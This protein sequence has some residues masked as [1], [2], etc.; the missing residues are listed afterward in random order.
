MSLFISFE[1]GEGGGKTTQI[2]K[3]ADLLTSEGYK[4]VTTREPGGTAEGDKIRD[5]IVQ[6]EGGDWSAMAEALLVLTARTMHVERVLKPALEEGKVVITDRFSDSTYAYQGYGRGL[7]LKTLDG[8]HNN[9]IGDL[10]PDLTFILDVDPKEGLSRS[11][12]RLASEQLG[13]DQTEDRFERL[14]VEFH[15]KI[16]NGFLEIAANEPER[17]VVIDASQSIED[18]AEQIKARVLE[19][20]G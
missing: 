19:K 15:E 9:V 7:D 13:V 17:C 3:L 14:E 16:R 20:L 12:R 10:K 1:G 2:N 18:I 5:F 11:E 8:L 4:V 6:R